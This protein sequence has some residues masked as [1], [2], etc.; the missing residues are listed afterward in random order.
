MGQRDVTANKVFLLGLDSTSFPF[1]KENLGALPTLRELLRQ[2]HVVETENEAPLFTASD[3]AT[4]ASG[5]QAGG[6][7]Y[8]FPMQWDP[9]AMKFRRVGGEWPGFEPFWHD[10]ARDG[11]D[12]VVFDAVDVPLAP[13]ALGIQITEWN[14]QESI[15]ADSNPPGLLRELERRFGRRPIGEEI[16]IK[17]SRRTLEQMRDT[18]IRSLRT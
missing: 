13:N 12:T 15:A 18:L 4:F 5:S 3:Y 10:F 1:I 17:K 6:H 9:P 8:Y 14:T 2:G 7:G 16:R 11:I